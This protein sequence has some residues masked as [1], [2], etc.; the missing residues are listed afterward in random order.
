MPSKAVVS[1]RNEFD[2]M[3]PPPKK[4]RVDTQTIEPGAATLPK[5]FMRPSRTLK[6]KEKEMKR[7][8][9]EELDNSTFKKRFE[10]D[11]TVKHQKGD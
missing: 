7:V 8:K 11:L 5:G 4:I 9:K 2:A 1:S 6:D 3:S 10:Y